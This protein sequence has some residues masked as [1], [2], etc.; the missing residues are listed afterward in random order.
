MS[1]PPLVI[2]SCDA[3]RETWLPF[4]RLW[5]KFSGGRVQAVYLITESAFFPERPDV[6]VLHPRKEEYRGSAD[7]MGMVAS[8]LKQIDSDYFFFSLDDFFLKGPL[9]WE[10]IE[11]Y[12]RIAARDGCDTVTLGV[13]DTTRR[14]HPCNIPDSPEL[15]AVDADSPYFLTTSPALWNRRSFLELIGSRHGS[16]WEFE[17]TAPQAVTQKLRQYMVDRN[18]MF[19]T[20]V[21]PY[22]CEF[23]AGVG[24]APVLSDS[25]IAKGKWQKGMPA[26]LAHHGVSGIAFWKRGFH[27]YY[28]HPIAGTFMRKL[29]IR[30]HVVKELLVDVAIR[31]QLRSKAWRTL[32]ERLHRAF[33]ADGGR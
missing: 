24:V 3:F 33:R 21:W 6:K 31:P 22:Y 29:G 28:P 30:L 10:R 19:L 11:R 20:P 7:W 9:D 14:G 5:D 4:M 17:F 32:T 27:E 2:V 1:T 25:A 23:W 12:G 18:T 26:F 8:A 15:L 16:A 13:H